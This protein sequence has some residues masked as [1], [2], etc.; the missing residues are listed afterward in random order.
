[1]KK[2][3]HQN[4]NN[5]ERLCFNCCGVFPPE[6]PNCPVCL[7]EGGMLIND[8]NRIA[9]QIRHLIMRDQLGLI[10]FEA[11]AKISEREEKQKQKWIKNFDKIF[12]YVGI[13]ILIWAKEKKEY[14]PPKRKKKVS[15]Q[16]DNRGKLK[17]AIQRLSGLTNFIH[18]NKRVDGGVKHNNSGS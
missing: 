10:P 2:I 13:A 14:E 9:M 15:K 12:H 11:L 8:N 7:A 18:K 17:R 6:F 3:K 16:N 1:M 5:R 4:L